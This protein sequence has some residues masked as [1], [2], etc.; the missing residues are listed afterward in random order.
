M[1]LLLVPIL[2]AMGGFGVG[3]FSGS[4]YGWVFWLIVA[5]F[6]FFVLKKMGVI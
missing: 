6:G 4:S 5:A 3:W 2:S 1:P